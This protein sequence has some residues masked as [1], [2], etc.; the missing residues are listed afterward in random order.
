MRK[1]DEKIR[2]DKKKDKKNKRMFDTPAF[3]LEWPLSRRL[4]FLLNGCVKPLH[5][6]AVVRH[7]PV[8]VLGGVSLF[9]V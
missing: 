1:G 3:E 8:G 6:R 9:K 5:H 2:N 7:E 4:G